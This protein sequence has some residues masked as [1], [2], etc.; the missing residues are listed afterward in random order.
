MTEL[1][2]RIRESSDRAFDKHVITLLHACGV[3]RSW[4]CGRPNDSAYAFTI[5]TIPG[6]LIITGDLS[7]L[8]VGRTYDM[9]PWCR[10]SVDSTGYFFEKADHTFN[11]VEF[12]EEMFDA[13]RNDR[14]AELQKE[15]K[16]YQDDDEEFDAGVWE[17]EK[18]TIVEQIEQL[19]E[20]CIQD[21]GG[22]QA[23]YADLRDHFDDFPNW[24]D[25]TPQMY[26]L[27][28]AVRWFVM[29]NND[30]PIGRPE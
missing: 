3:Y 9:L 5:T 11:K 30:E 27:R 22:E 7:T 17:D 8:V 28:D 20:Y 26:W 19:D 29:N 14:I 23:A 13:W 10:G 2:K 21:E 12:V 16:A 25:Y 6:Y 18:K 1:E 24:R 4:R 15:L